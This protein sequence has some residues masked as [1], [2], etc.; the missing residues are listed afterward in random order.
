MKYLNFLLLLSLFTQASTLEELAEPYFNRSEF[1]RMVSNP[2]G[3]YIATETYYNSREHLEIIDVKAQ[4][5][6]V[7]FE[8]STG[9]HS[10]ISEILWIDSDSL[11]ISIKPISDFKVYQNY[12]VIH[13][14]YENAVSVKSSFNFRSKGWIIDPLLEIKN[15]IYFAYLPENRTNISAGVFKTDLTN[16]ESYKNSISPQY[17]ITTYVKDSFYWLTGPERKIDF[18]MSKKDKT[19]HYWVNDHN[20]WRKIKS[21][22]SES[23]DVIYPQGITSDGNFIVLKKLQDK[24]KTGVYLLSSDNLKVLE[25]IYYNDS[26]DIYDVEFDSLTNTIVSLRYEDNGIINDIPINDKLGNAVEILKNKYKNLDSYLISYSKDFKNFIFVIH[27]FKNSGFYVQVNL[28]NQTAKKLI[29]KS[30]WK[31]D[32][33]KADLVQ[34]NHIT[35]D[36]YRI[37]SYLSVPESK[38]INA[39]LVMPHGGPIGARSYGYYDGLSHFLA[40]FGIAVLKVNYRGSSGYGKKFLDAGKKMWGTKIEEDID[41]VVSSVLKKYPSIKNNICAGGIS[42]G[43]YSALMLHINYPDRYKCVISVAA[44]TDLP[45]MFTS[46]DWNKSNRAVKQM[47][48]IVG[49]PQHDLELL[50]SISPLYNA[51]K[52]KSPVLLIHGTDDERVS[53][54]HSI[55]MNII[56]TKL[57]KSVDIEIMKGVKH[58]FISMQD[59]IFYV[60]RVLKFINSILNLNLKYN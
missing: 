46:S 34:I 8:G 29:D 35:D 36:G 56:L 59:E 32:L 54:E 44:P 49:D 28:H 20:K 53:S 2:D 30:D 52:I 5:T 17:N 22:S 18:V 39:L 16:F 9:V 11:I 26:H 48:E 12:K 3:K 19:I 58:G 47:I 7:V 10:T 45:L 38:R 4:K 27:N 43:G 15:K 55:R 25:E 31:N 23:E 13:L 33:V 1:V 57:G 6:Y 24:D 14:N 37:E 40:N 51:D 50:K 21:I 60:V 42:Y 41:S